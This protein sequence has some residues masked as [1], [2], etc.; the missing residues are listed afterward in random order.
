[1]HIHVSIL[2]QIPLPSG[3]PH[4]LEQSSLSYA[5]GPGWLSILNIAVRS[6]PFHTPE[7]SPHPLAAINSFS[8]S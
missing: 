5:V 4:N 2:S 8:K 1:M 3:L 6:S 7:L